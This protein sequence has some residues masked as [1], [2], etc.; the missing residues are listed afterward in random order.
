MRN[1]IINLS[2]VPPS[3]K[4]EELTDLSINKELQ[5]LTTEAEKQTNQNNLTSAAGH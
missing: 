1:I 2:L 4:L 5:K 3:T